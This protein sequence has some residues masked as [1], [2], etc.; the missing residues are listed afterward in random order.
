MFTRIAAKKSEWEDASVSMGWYGLTV[1]LVCV[2]HVPG[3]R[4]LAEVEQ[5]LE[6][7]RVRRVELE[8]Q[9]ESAVSCPSNQQT[10]DL[11][12]DLAAVRLNVAGPDLLAT[13]YGQALVAAVEREREIQHLQTRIEK[14]YERRIAKQQKRIQELETERAEWVA[15][16]D[17]EIIAHSALT[18]MRRYLQDH[19]QAT[20][21]I[22]R[23]GVTMGIYTLG[24]DGVAFSED[25]GLVRLNDEELEAGRVW[26][27]KQT[28][29]PVIVTRQPIGKGK[30]T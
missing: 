10:P 29:R 22:Q 21:P 6:G 1:A 3:L 18:A 15:W 7:E 13:A 4:R 8:R 28:G 25:H 9:L 17:A 5:L 23:N 2:R 30:Q 19:E 26:V 11:E 16:R 24:P 14:Q 27:C 20:I 12:K